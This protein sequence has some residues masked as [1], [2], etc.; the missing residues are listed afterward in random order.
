MV[1]DIFMLIVLI[2][3]MIQTRRQLKNLELKQKDLEWQIES[4]TKVAAP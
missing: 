3:F 2:A 1:F 4:R